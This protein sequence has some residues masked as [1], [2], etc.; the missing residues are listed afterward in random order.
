MKKSNTRTWAIA[1]MGASAIAAQAQ[2]VAPASGVSLY[3]LVDAGVEVVSNVGTS[4]SLTR[5]PSNTGTL[6]SRVSRSRMS[7]ISPPCLALSIWEAR[8]GCRQVSG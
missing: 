1:L 8:A 6:P 5:M 3:G 4:G 7:S 2:T